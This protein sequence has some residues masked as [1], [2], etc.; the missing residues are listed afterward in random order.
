[1]ETLAR[2]EGHTR[3]AL[4]AAADGD[5]WGQMVANGRASLGLAAGAGGRDRA[6]PRAPGPGQRRRGAIS[7]WRSPRAPR[8]G[9]FGRACRH[10]DRHPRA[11]RRHLARG[12][13]PGGLGGGGRRDRARGP[14]GRGPAPGGVP[15]PGGRRPGAQALRGQRPRRRR[16]GPAD[17]RGRAARLR[18]RPAQRHLVRRAAAAAGGARDRAGAP[19]QLH[20]GP[21]R[22]HAPS[23]CGW[24]PRGWTAATCRRSRAWAT[25]GRARSWPSAG[26][27]RTCPPSW[28]SASRRRMSLINGAP[29]A[30][31]LL[32]DAILCAE[33]HAGGRGGGVLPGGGGVRRRAGHLRRAP[34]GA[35]GRPVPD[36]GPAGDPRRDRG[37]GAAARVGRP[38]AA[39]GQLPRSCPGCWAT[40]TAWWPLR[41]MRLRSPC[42]RSATTRSSCSAT[43]DADLGDIVSNGGFHNGAAPACIDGLTFA[44]ADLAQLAQHQLQRL[45]TSREAMPGLDSLALGTLQMV[46]AGYAEEARAAVVPS[47][48]PLPGFGHNDV[49]APSFHAWNRC[50]RVRGFVVGSLTCLAVMAAQSFARTGR[51]FPP[52]LREFGELV[53]EICPP[54]VERRSVGAELGLLGCA[55]GWWDPGVAVG[56]AFTAA[57]E[58]W[59]S[60][61]S[62]WAAR[63]STWS[64]GKPDSALQVWRGNMRYM[65]YAAN[66][67][68]YGGLSTFCQ[69]AGRARTHP[70]Q[71][72][73][74]APS[75]SPPQTAHREYTAGST[76]S[77]KD[78]SPGR[79]CEPRHAQTIGRMLRSLAHTLA[80][81]PRR[82]LIATFVFVV[83]AGAIGGPLAGALKS[84][85]GFAPPNSDSQVATN[86]LQRASGTEASPGI[87]LL[88]QHARG[89][90]GGSRPDRA[91]STRG[92]V[93]SRAW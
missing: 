9:W 21:R 92:C 28:S 35:V 83:I 56:G 11:P 19:G 44:L 54:V 69:V 86:M 58:G 1:M 3:F 79:L 24:S 63:P 61:A 65:D 87:V 13:C 84:S 43:A 8:R 33:Q 75:R 51:D 27:L 81:H 37:R 62:A 2:R 47:L 68:R 53:L 59:V 64:C 73:V 88:R 34:G 29:C 66:L 31:A 17:D 12:V 52:A 26:C 85:G 46:G 82:T 90:G 70:S 6:R 32:A 7:C 14:G 16:L 48:L 40:P 10:R 76:R 78:T 72:A 45:Q 71:A 15:G 91:A 57:G 55:F 4:L 5:L 49:P 39:A 77:R 22:G 23:W 60:G 93:T 38:P 30:P 80:A 36:R 18:A 50:D 74:N 89:A 20:R 67:R 42:P 41:V 25:A